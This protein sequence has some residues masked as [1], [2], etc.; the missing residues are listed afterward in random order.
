MIMLHLS[1]RFRMLSSRSSLG[2]AIK[3]K[4]KCGHHALPFC[5][6]HSANKN[7]FWKVAYFRRSV[8][9]HDSKTL[10]WSGV[11]VVPSPEFLLPSHCYCKL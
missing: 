8:T 6:I 10:E 5:C 4:A 3:P 2:I 7:A 9:I 1:A 11:N